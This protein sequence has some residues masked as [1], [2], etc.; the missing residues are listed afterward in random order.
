MHGTAGMSDV[1]GLLLTKDLI[2]IDPEECTS[3]RAMV[4]FFGRRVHKVYEDTSLG[5]VLKDFKTELKL[6]ELWLLKRIF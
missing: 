5:E 6:W 3:V 4:E 1:V 2:V